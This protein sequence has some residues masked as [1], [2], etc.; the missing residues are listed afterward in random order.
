MAA[1]EAYDARAGRRSTQAR[2]PRLR[3]DEIAG[4]GIGVSPELQEA[5]VVAAGF[6][7]TAERFTRAGP[8]VERSRIVR[9][10]REHARVFVACFLETAEMQ[11][12]VGEAGLE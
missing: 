6:G 1:C 8:A 9:I 7:D 2:Q 11:V 5:L 4:V 3:V 10:E 12:R